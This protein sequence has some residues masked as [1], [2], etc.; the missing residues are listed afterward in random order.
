[1]KIKYYSRRSVV[2]WKVFTAQTSRSMINKIT[3]N[4]TTWRHGL[5]QGHPA[6]SILVVQYTAISRSSSSNSSIIIIAIIVKLIII[7]IIVKLR[8]V[9]S[10]MS[11]WHR[12]IEAVDPI[13]LTIYAFLLS[14]IFHSCLFYASAVSLVTFGTPEKLRD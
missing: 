7:A 5:G 6:L 9:F 14:A 3:D 12:H 11:S 1:M 13:H 4:I 8:K 2:R 10:V